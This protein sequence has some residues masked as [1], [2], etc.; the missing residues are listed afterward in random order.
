MG[1]GLL[2]IGVGVTYD[3]SQPAQRRDRRG[4]AS[5][6]RT[7]IDHPAENPFMPTIKFLN[8]K[9]T[10]EVEPGTDLRKAA[11]REG[12]QLYTGPHKYLNC[13]GWGQCASCKVLIKKGA[14]N[15]SRPGLW[16]RLRWW[17]DPLA[18]FAYMGKEKELR[19]ACQT[20]VT[21]NGEVEV[22]TRPPLNLH[23]EK[24]WG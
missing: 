13:M 14:E 7:E 4:S 15:V 20:R 3:F 18:M 17:L 2:E 22:E 12:I 1:P 23:G 19:M 21:G 16:E 6:L 24:F 11:I 9:K 10:V 5:P 8:E